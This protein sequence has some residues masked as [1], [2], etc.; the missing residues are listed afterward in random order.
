MCTWELVTAKHSL[1]TQQKRK[2]ASRV[3]L[4]DSGGTAAASPRLRGPLPPHR[5]PRRRWRMLTADGGGGVVPACFSRF[6]AWWSSPPPYEFIARSGRHRLASPT[7]QSES[8]SPASPALDLAIAGLH[9]RFLI[10]P[11]RPGQQAPS[12][13]HAVAFGLER[14]MHGETKAR[15][16]AR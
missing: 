4:G 15:V 12:D 1:W 14:L 8:R 9:H 5:S 3:V 7:S 16:H 11:S 10:W 6:P 13:L 2:K